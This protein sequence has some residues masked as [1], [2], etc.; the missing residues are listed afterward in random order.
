[1]KEIAKEPWNYVFSEETHGQYLLTVVCG[2]VGIYEVTIRLTPEQ[3]GRYQHD[4]LGYI[5]SLAEQVRSSP[6]SF[7]PQK[8]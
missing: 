6:P 8:A 4:G 7:D 3:A 2:G 1:M 5:A